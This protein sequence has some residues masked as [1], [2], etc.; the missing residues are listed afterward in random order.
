VLKISLKDNLD[1]IYDTI[2]LFKKNKREVIYDAEHYFDGFKSNK[3]YALETLKIAKKAGADCIVLCETNG[4]CMPDEVSKIVKETKQKVKTKLGIHC[5]N[6]SGMAI[7]NS[8]AAIETGAEHVQGTING[9]GERTGNADLI[10]IILNL[11]L[12]KN[13]NCISKNKIKDLKI[14]GSL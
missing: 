7:A 1:L 9:V 13:H 12:K 11:Q 10:P 14:Y 4:G 6:D 2:K 3:R 5:H 8:M